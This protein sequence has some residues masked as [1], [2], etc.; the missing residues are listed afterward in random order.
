MA[1]KPIQVTS[2]L[3]IEPTVFVWEEVNS[4]T[5][6]CLYRILSIWYGSVEMELILGR[7]FEQKVKWCKWLLNPERLRAYEVEVWMRWS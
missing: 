1:S 2:K 4:E 7:A 6:S 3:F 5:P